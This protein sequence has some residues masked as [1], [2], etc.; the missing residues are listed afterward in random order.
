MMTQI[1]FINVIKRYKNFEALRELS[2]SLGLNEFTALVGNNG[3][4]KTT[5]INI[6]TNLISYDSGEVKVFGKR[7]TPSYVS[8]KNKLGIL[9]SNSILINEFTP[10]E[11]LA[12]V[13]KFQNVDSLDIKRRIED[14]IDTFKISNS[15]N[16]LI[17]NF[18]SG[19]QMKISF[20]STIIHNPQ[21]LILDEPFI[22]LDIQ[23]IDFLLTLLLSF[24]KKRTIFITSHNLD[25][26]ANL[27][28]R[29]LIMQEGKIIDDIYK[30]ANNSI[31][32]IKT[33]IKER[34]IIQHNNIN[35]LNWLR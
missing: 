30:D 23:T 15:K 1:E 35:L 8:Y 2:F 28:E 5:T 13:C 9:L 3:C 25:L 6:L 19:D 4:G 18:S 34:L 7:V 22:Y 33:L 16:K 11:Y 26:I 21:I 10:Y 24:R 17:G 12:F 20:A 27:C 29:F 31:E 14:V 32:S